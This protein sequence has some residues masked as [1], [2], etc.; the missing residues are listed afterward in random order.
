VLSLLLASA[1]LSVVHGK[2]HCGCVTFSWLFDSG[3]ELGAPEAG[4]TASL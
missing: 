1:L 2:K 4:K 3:S